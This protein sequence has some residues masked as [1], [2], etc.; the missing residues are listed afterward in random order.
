MLS[1]VLDNIVTILLNY[2]IS[3]GMQMKNTKVLSILLAIVILLPF[4]ILSENAVEDADSGCDLA[5]CA[6]DVQEAYSEELAAEQ[7]KTLND[8]LN[9]TEYLTRN[10]A[11]TI[12]YNTI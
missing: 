3:G 11:A 6:A 5:G 1:F 10:Y 4:G 9:N 12:Y 7:E 8:D 2:K